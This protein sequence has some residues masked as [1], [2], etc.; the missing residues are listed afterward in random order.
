MCSSD[1]TVEYMCV[2]YTQVP[3]GVDEDGQTYKALLLREYETLL[4]D[5]Q[6]LSEDVAAEAAKANPNTA[7]LNAM[8]DFETYFG[9]AYDCYVAKCEAIKAA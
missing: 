7:L 2:Y 8:K 1:L 4:E 5:Y 9:D 6:V 3:D